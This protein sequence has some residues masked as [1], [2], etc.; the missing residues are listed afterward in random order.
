MHLLI[1]WTVSDLYKLYQEYDGQLS[2]KHMIS[3]LSLYYGEELMI[4]RL[5]GC[6]NVIGFRRFILRSMT[7][8]AEI[9]IAED[10][11]KI[12]AIVRKIISEVKEI[13]NVLNRYD[14]DQFTYSNICESTSETLLTLVSRLVSKGKK[15]KVALLISQ[16][17]QQDI[18]LSPN[19]TTLGLALKLHH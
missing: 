12:E 1:T 18:A 13:P 15:N 16:C 19:Q 5:E 8:V 9:D 11:D 14:L 3:N 6:A 17:I 7:L 2:S 4:L 10:E